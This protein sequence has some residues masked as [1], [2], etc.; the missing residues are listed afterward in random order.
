LE[1]A[2]AERVPSAAGLGPVPAAAAAVFGDVL[3]TAIRYAELLAGP[4]VER[5]LIGPAEASR[6]WDRHL[7]NSAAIAGLAPAGGWIVDVGSGAGLPGLVLAL[8]LPSARLTLVEPMARRVAFLDECVG[9]LGLTNVEVRRGRAEELSGDLAADMVTARAV[10]PLAKLAALC[11]GLARPGGLVVAM[12]GSSAAAELASATAE[13]AD[14][15]VTDARVAQVGSGTGPGAAT[16][17]MFT[18]AGRRAER[19]V[20]RNGRG[21]G[22]GSRRRSGPGRRRGG[23]AR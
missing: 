9:E 10:A 20:R 6:I 23:S 2:S 11:A 5:G 7:F 18:V 19:E 1:H 17:V 13:L 15:G 21:P 3:P 4:G 16:V 8:L 14:L 22:R 12:K